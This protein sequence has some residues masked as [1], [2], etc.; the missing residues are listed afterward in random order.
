MRLDRISICFHANSLAQW[1]SAR[2]AIASTALW[3]FG[4]SCCIE[5]RGKSWM[6][7]VTK[8]KG[9]DKKVK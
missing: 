7:Y 1:L 9:V 5:S 6:R 3:L 2:P 4:T 8:V